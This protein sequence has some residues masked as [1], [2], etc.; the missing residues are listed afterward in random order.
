MQSIIKEQIAESEPFLKPVTH[1]S[2]KRRGPL[3]SHIKITWNGGLKKLRTFSGLHTS[4][5]KSGACYSAADESMPSIRADWLGTGFINACVRLNMHG[6]A[7]L[8]LIIAPLCSQNSLSL[9]L[10]PART[11]QREA[12]QCYGRLQATV[13]RT[14]GDSLGAEALTSR[15]RRDILR[16]GRFPA[17][18]CRWS[19]A[20]SVHLIS[21]FSFN[22]GNL[23]YCTETVDW[24]LPTV[25]KSAPQVMFL[26]VCA[27]LITHDRKEGDSLL[28]FKCC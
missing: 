13:K 9:W 22:R 2:R 19:F 15:I 16:A 12:H 6:A 18:H 17:Y 21:P 4:H 1:E 5:F 7:W 28:V 25:I 11:T 26:S 24:H 3:K 8:A 20:V 23:I 10:R 14:P 27:W